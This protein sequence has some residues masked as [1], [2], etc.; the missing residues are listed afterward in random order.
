VDFAALT[1]SSLLTFG[2][3]VLSATIASAEVPPMPEA[4]DGI[5]QTILTVKPSV[6]KDTDDVP[7]SQYDKWSIAG[8]FTQ[9]TSFVFDAENYPVSLILNQDA[10]L[11]SATVPAGT[12]EKSSSPNFPKWK[13]R[14]RGSEPDIPGAEG[15]RTGKF[16]VVPSRLGPLNRM[17]FRQTGRLTPIPIDVNYTSDSDPTEP[18]LRATLLFYDASGVPQCATTLIACKRKSADKRLSCFSTL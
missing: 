2:L 4:C 17:P 3:G 10:L 16:R 6:F 9:F 13:F 1:R 8:Q 14:L 11:Y 18:I 15:W 7:G 12:F 5:E